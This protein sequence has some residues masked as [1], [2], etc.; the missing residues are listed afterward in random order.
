L[1]KVLN[2]ATASILLQFHV[3]QFLVLSYR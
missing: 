1:G 3:L 2:F